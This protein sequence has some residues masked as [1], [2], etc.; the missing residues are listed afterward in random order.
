MPA[1]PP[2]RGRRVF[3]TILVVAAGAW[4]GH[5]LWRHAGELAA[6]AASLAPERLVL[7]LLPGLAARTLSALTYY[8]ILARI[9]PG[10][11]SF[12]HLVTP[13]FASQV[14]RYLPGK[15]WSVFYQVGSFARWVR[16]RDVWEANLLEF[17]VGNTNSLLVALCV[18]VHFAGAS[19]AALGLFALACACVY[20]AL[21]R[22]LFGRVLAFGSG[23]MLRGDRE[24]AER[25]G[26]HSGAITASLELE[27]LVFFAAFAL[28]VPPGTGL[29]DAMTLAALYTVAWIAG[30]LA[31]VLPDGWVVREASFVWLGSQLGYAASELL[32]LSLVARVFF[33]VLDLVAVLASALVDRALGAPGEAAP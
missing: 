19:A 1:S 22:S 32:V 23:Q 30:F 6:S 2:E 14:V 11:P 3:G 15:V 5:A 31:F 29:T 7:A 9:A 12:R 26:A 24:A 33:V 4:L 16:G 13:Y 27:W 10:L 18:L 17:A 28:L 21:R 8:L 25:G 20:G